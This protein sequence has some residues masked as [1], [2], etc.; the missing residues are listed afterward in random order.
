MRIGPWTITRS[1]PRAAGLEILQA[2]EAAVRGS[3]GAV[4]VDRALQH[5]VALACI[6]AVARGIAQVPFN[7]HQRRPDGGSDILSDEPLYEVVH[8]LPSRSSNERPAGLTSFEWRETL[9][10]HAMLGNGWCYLNRVGGSVV[11]IVNL[12][13]E[14]VRIEEIQRRAQYLVKLGDDKDEIPV[15]RDQLLHLRSTSWDGVAGMDWLDLVK[16]S[17]GL[18]IDAEK[19]QRNLFAGGVRYGVLSADMPGLPDDAIEKIK[20][21]FSSEGRKNVAWLDFG[22][23]Y[24]PFREN[25]Q[26]AQQLETRQHQIEEVCR[27]FGV[28]PQMVGFS[29]KTATFASAESFFTAHV[30][31]TLA[32]WA[33][34]LEQAMYRDVLTEQQRAQGWFFKLNLQGLLRGDTKARS[35]MYEI[36]HR[37]SALSPNE[38]RALEDFNPYDGGDVY[39]Q[40]LNM[41]EVGANA[42]DPGDPND[43]DDAPQ[44]RLITR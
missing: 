26:E 24:V 1:R 39:F 25:S 7:L 42:D 21:A 4:T 22:V 37:I 23:K 15:R 10:A 40:Q 13:P 17:L 19:D 11:E 34:A 32:P 16:Q 41:A 28:F 12:K 35:A 5:A 14:W 6:R 31:H 30:I 3:T 38:I 29:D 18:S 43:D 20:A 36:L 27:A 44:V 2:I 9:I 33:E 8:R